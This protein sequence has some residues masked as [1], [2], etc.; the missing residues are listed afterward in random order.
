[1]FRA[2]K[3]DPNHIY[4][5][6]IPNSTPTAARPLQKARSKMQRAESFARRFTLMNGDHEQHG[7]KSK[8]RLYMMFAAAIGT[9]FIT[10]LLSTMNDGNSINLRFSSNNKNQKDTKIKTN[11]FSYSKKEKSPYEQIWINSKLPGWA[12]KKKEFRRIEKTIPASERICYVHV[13]KAGGSSVGCSLGFSLHCNHTQAPLEGL[14]PQRATRLFHADTYDCHDD[15]AYF[16]FVVRDPIERIKSAFL[17]ERPTSE[18][19]L[20]KRFPELYERRKNLYLDC[21][22]FGVFESFVQDGLTKHGRASDV[23]KIRAFTAVRGERHFSCH[24]YFNYQFHLEGI[25]SDGKILVIRNEH[26]IEDWNGAEHFIGGE[27]EI[28]PPE[29]ANTTIVAVNKSKKDGKDKELSEEST[30]ILCRQL[31]NEIVNYKKILRRALNLNYAQVEQ[32]VE[33]LRE[34]CPEYAD[35]EEGECPVAMPDIR[36]KLINTRGYEDMVMEDGYYINKEKLETTMHTKQAEEKMEAKE[37]MDDD[38]YALPYS[39]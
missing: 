13:G 34:T 11:K 36:E 20:K 18:K 24:M 27:R 28:I 4:V 25:P 10:H 39:V 2:L 29:E 12:K 33:E 17:Y 16:L 32:S 38:G 31:C 8:S 14:L 6:C 9:I 5:M 15:S 22:S 19:S 7:S 26:L 30:K 23:C 37:L 35:V 1:M 21:P 3:E